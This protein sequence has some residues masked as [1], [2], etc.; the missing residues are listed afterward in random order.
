MEQNPS[1]PDES[2]LRPLGD[3]GWLGL[4]PSAT[5]DRWQL[6]V[7]PQICGRTG[8]LHGGC[9]LAA[10]TTAAEQA[11]G[12][13]LVWATAQYLARA[14]VGEVVDYRV[15][16]VSSG[17]TVSQVRATATVGERVIA[18]FMGA[19]G[20]R[21]GAN[22]YRW[23][24]PPEVPAPEGCRGYELSSEPEGSFH[25]TVELRVA[26]LDAAAGTAAFWVRMPDGVHSTSAGL[27]MLGDY[28]PAGF[29]LVLSE[30]EKP[31]ASL[32]NT[33]R[34][35]GVEHSD[36]LLMDIRLGAVTDGA[37][38]GELRAWSQSGRLLS[39]ASQSF[40]FNV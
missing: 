13:P 25:R 15:S 4:T 21:A 14:A 20:Q 19:F 8:Y 18:E 5:G 29:R 22:Q 10:A 3:H 1:V 40:S 37:A 24:A 34:V 39:L 2:T 33:V 7:R 11:T 36:W 23:G 30:T 27:A 38:H 6:T 32:D 12:R 31:A 17:K 26:A 35:V 16:T 28:V 9:S